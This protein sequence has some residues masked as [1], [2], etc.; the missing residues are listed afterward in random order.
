MFKLFKIILLSTPIFLV[1]SFETHAQ[2]SLATALNSES[3]K[4]VGLAAATATNFR[5]NGAKAEV[6]LAVMN[7]G[8][9][10]EDPTSSLLPQ[11]VKDIYQFKEL[12]LH[13][14][15]MYRWFSCVN[16]SRGK[17]TKSLESLAPELKKC[18]SLSNPQTQIDCMASVVNET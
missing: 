7:A 5:D 15:R 18:Q 11:I 16:E 3:C 17:K 8:I 12:S 13:S 10:K 6:A 9:P 1:N 2:E 4:R 14:H